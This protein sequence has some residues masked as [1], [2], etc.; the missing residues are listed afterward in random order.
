MNVWSLSI[1]NVTGAPIRHLPPEGVEVVVAKPRVDPPALRVKIERAY[2]QSPAGHCQHCG[3]ELSITN[4][5]YRY[6]S[7]QCR[8]QAN[9]AKR[10]VSRIAKATARK[11]GRTCQHCHQPMPAETHGHVKYCSAECFRSERNMR[12]RVTN[13]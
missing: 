10:N 6:C 2:R 13:A 9:Q 1:G 7:I 11:A 4:N 3:V 12:K 5:K 8:N